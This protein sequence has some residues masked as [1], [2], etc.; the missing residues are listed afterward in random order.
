M[1]IN[2]HGLICPVNWDKQPFYCN[3]IAVDKNGDCYAYENKP[4]VFQDIRWIA[5]R[6]PKRGRNATCLGDVFWFLFKVKPP[7]DFTQCL[8]QRPKTTHI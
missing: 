2:E 6:T 4:E 7:T 3:W 8:W 5:N 1:D